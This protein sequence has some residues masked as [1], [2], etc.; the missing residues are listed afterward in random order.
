[1]SLFDS[2]RSGQ[3]FELDDA[4][5]RVLAA[6][7]QERDTDIGLLNLKRAASKLNAEQKAQLAGRLAEISLGQLFALVH[8]AP[9]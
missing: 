7:S 5:R 6:W 8:G 3:A 9:E 4:V 2:G 1:M